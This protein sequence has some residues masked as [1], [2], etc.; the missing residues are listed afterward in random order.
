MV[1][2]SKEEGDLGR[3]TK[4]RFAAWQPHGVITEVLEKLF[5]DDES[6][7]R[8]TREAIHDAVETILDHGINV[9]LV[10]GTVKNNLEPELW[11]RMDV[12]QFRQR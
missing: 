10:H 9:M 8:L 11:I 12:D 6:Q 4:V 2:E 5:Y 3:L 1:R 7:W